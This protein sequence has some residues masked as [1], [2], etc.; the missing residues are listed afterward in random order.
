MNINDVVDSP[1]L[2]DFHNSNLSIYAYDYPYSGGI[3]LRIETRSFIDPD[4]TIS[5]KEHFY[6]VDQMTTKEIDLYDRT[7]QS[8]LV[9]TQKEAQNLL[10]SLWKIGIRP[11][12][13]EGS[14]GQIGAIKD[15]LSDM[16][17]LVEHIGKCKL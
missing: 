12:D 9:I 14:V 4:G 1:R 17:K 8:P 10:D 11:T 3:E 2:R 5:N 13:G 7:V 16:R 6:T 15:H